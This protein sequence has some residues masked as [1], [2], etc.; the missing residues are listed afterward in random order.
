MKNLLI[1]SILLI[2]SANIFAQNYFQQEVNYKIDVKL[3]DEEHSL[4]AFE[5]VE[6]INNSPDTL[7]F[8]YFH[9]WANAY[10]NNKTALA[11]QMATAGNGKLYFNYKEIGGYI[12]SLD[13]K[14]DGKLAKTEAH[15]KHID[16]CKLLL[17]KPL[18]PG[19]R[20]SITT[21]FY[22]K[23]PGDISRLGHDGQSYQITQWYP[24]PAVYDQTGWHEMPYLNM[25]EFYSEFGTFEVNISVPK[26]YV[27]GATGNLQNNDEKNWLDSLASQKITGKNLEN[28]AE[29]S[30]KTITFKQDKIHDF[31]W[32][33]NKD[34]YVSKSEQAL[35]S[36]KK[37]TS[38][39]MFTDKYLW[40]EATDYIN[41]AV[42]FYSEWVGEYPY[43]NC[44]AVQGALSAG[45][46]M[47]Y[48]TI[49]VISAGFDKKTLEQ[50]I[51]HEVGHNWFYGILA[52]NERDYT[53]LDEG[54]NSYYEARYMLH[55]FPESVFGE[56]LGFPSDTTTKFM[57]LGKLPYR[58]GAEFIYDVAAYM[59]SDQPLN[60]HAE[61]FTTFSYGAVPY[62]KAPVAF[63]LL[64]GYVG[65]EEF[66]KIMQS[67]YEEWKFKHPQPEDLENHFRENCSKNVDWFFDD[68]IK[69]TKKIDYKVKHR[70]KKLIVKNR[71][72]INSPFTITAYHKG[73]K[74]YSQWY[75]GSHRTQ[76]I[77]LPDSIKYNKIILDPNFQNMDFDRY[78]NQVHKRWI[79]RKWKPID[80]NFAYSFGNFDKRN[81]NL[82]PIA[83]WNSANN[84]ML[85]LMFHN[86]QLPQRRFQYYIA[87][88][89]CFSEAP[90]AGEADFRYKRFGY[91]GFP[92]IIYRL[93][94]S[95]YA[96][97]NFLLLNIPV[98]TNI[99]PFSVFRIKGEVDFRL[100]NFKNSDKAEKHLKIAGY[101]F[102]DRHKIGQ[103]NYLANVKYTLSKRSIFK[104]YDFT[105]NADFND[106]F[107]SFWAEA[108]YRV[109][110]YKSLMGGLDL[111]FFAGQNVRL[112]G[113]SG[114]EDYKWDYH[115]FER[116]V[117]NTKTTGWLSQQFIESEGGFIT[118]MQNEFKFAVFAVN[119]QTSIPKVPLVKPYFNIAASYSWDAFYAYS[120]NFE[121]ISYETGIMLSIVPDRMEIYF[122]I[123]ASKNIQDVQTGTNY[124]EKIRFVFNLYNL[125]EYFK[126]F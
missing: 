30:Y 77:R 13:F 114:A 85:G 33:A 110:H 4:T 96:D 50:I 126:K 116:G 67:F 27:V 2:F 119:V 58:Y 57:N 8:I 56:V 76:K 18:M 31:A 61:D 28:P 20:I 71:G 24:K 79:L 80:I 48:P 98:P 99:Y 125:Q 69:T 70:N 86:Y 7:D 73:K 62:M 52:F 103:N 113:I 107:F 45:G 112:G 44:T 66:D 10:K 65:R 68:V 84:L 106:S 124:K 108:N 111:R 37:V 117:G 121:P 122:P 72:H 21:P 22:V 75:E 34:Y 26:Q 19:E 17:N 53:F 35:Q 64:E 15:E 38:W 3:N 12:D 104:P 91:N 25:G 87:P 83:S 94:Y 47:E 1:L 101:Y 89:Y 100:N 32:F 11:K 6:Y 16:I 123:Y 92:D 9:L 59:A 78:N 81:I 29:N 95:V 63:Y 120:P 41:D 23:L 90:L 93:N 14:I 105:F 74:V 54:I 60:V 36:G 42:R 118:P 49:T 97:N 55:K 102:P 5:T 82:L 46:G 43:D 88:M 51:M 109:L 40:N 115:F 39:A